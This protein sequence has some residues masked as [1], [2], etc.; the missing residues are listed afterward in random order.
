LDLTW[1][2]VGQATDVA[3]TLLTFAVGLDKSFVNALIVA[4]VMIK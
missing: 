1:K 4:A 2:E 3:T